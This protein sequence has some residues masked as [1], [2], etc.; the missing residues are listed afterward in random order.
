MIDSHVTLDP[1]NEIYENV[2]LNNAV[3]KNVT[4]WHFYHFLDI[5]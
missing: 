4:L 3:D 2:I 1:V 5:I